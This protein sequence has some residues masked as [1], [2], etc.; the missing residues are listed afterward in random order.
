MFGDIPER[1]LE[2]MRRLEAIDARDRVDGTPRDKR[3]RQIPPETAKF[4]AIVASSTPQGNFVE[5]GTSAGYSSLYLGLAC[6]ERGVRLTTFEVLEEKAHMAQETFR[7]AGMDDIIK[8]IVGDAREYLSGLNGI[9]FCFLDAEK[10]VYLECYELIV[11]KLVRGG[12][13]VADNVISHAETLQSLV[14]RAMADRRVDAVVVPIGRG[15]LLC[16]RIL[17]G[18]E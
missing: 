14:D 7:L 5:I 13:L 16:R 2:Q 17:N 4:L 10:E 1:V 11:P 18:R 3:L 6:R 8:V 12:L 15:E 9:S